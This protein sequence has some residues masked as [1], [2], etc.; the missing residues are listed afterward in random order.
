MKGSASANS[1]A[2]AP[3]CSSQSH[4]CCQR[5]GAARGCKT[6]GA[7][8][9]LLGSPCGTCTIRATQSPVAA[10]PPP[11]VC[12]TRDA[13]RGLCTRASQHTPASMHAHW[14]TRKG[15]AKHVHQAGDAAHCVHAER[16]AP[17]AAAPHALAGRP[18]R[19]SRCPAS[20]PA[21]CQGRAQ[22]GSA[23]G[24]IRR[25]RRRRRRRRVDGAACVLQAV[26]ERVMQR[27][28]RTRKHACTSAPSST[29]AHAH[30]RACMSA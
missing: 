15:N 6:S 25:R 12:R 16:C 18:G 10:A 22:A 24:A 23:A 30:A 14:R 4:C 28:T 3:R 13:G 19:H 1:H 21:G 29:H 17:P 5:P 27:G 20:T 11:A 26:N 7:T 2:R 9:R 8:D